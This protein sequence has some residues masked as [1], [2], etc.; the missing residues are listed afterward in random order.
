LD[1][2]VTTNRYE[3]MAYAAESRSTALG[4]TPGIAPFDRN[5]D[6]GTVWPPDS[7]DSQ[8][9]YSRHKWHSAQFRMDNMKQSGYWTTLLGQN[10]FRLK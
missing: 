4:M 9:P 6:L 5:I 2:S 10:G 7:Q 1:I 3:I 8:A